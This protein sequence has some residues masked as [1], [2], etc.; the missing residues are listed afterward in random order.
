MS[1]IP[2]AARETVKT[3]AFGRCER[4]S[5]GSATDIHHRMRRREGGHAVSNLVLLCRTCHEY[6]HKNPRI[7]QSEGFI[8]PA[9]QFGVDSTAPVKTWRGWACHDDEGNFTHVT[10]HP[11]EGAPNREKE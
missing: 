10:E 5:A 3:R 6:C 2:T 7:A 1:K 11:I 4:C 9:N 8:I